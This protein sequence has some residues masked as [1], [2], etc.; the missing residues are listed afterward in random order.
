MPPQFISF[1]KD[2]LWGAATSAFQIEGS[3]LADGAAK[4]NWYNWT[5]TPGKVDR[6]QDAD[7]AC[8]H[9]HRYLEDVALMKEMGLKTYRFSISWP[10]V[11][12]ERGRANEKA[13][14]FYRRLVD[15]VNQA[16][17][18]PNAT[19]FHWE[20]PVWIKG[21]WENPEI[22]PAFREYAEVVF[23]KLGKDVPYWATH[24]EPICVAQLGYLDGPFPPGKH[25]KKAYAKV[26]HHLTLAHH[27]TVKSYRQMNLGG[28]IGWVL[29]LT[30]SKTIHKGPV[31]IKHAK[32]LNDL[33]NGVFLAPSAGRSYPDFLFDYSGESASLYEKELKAVL[34]PLDFLGVNHY[35]PN[36]TQYSPGANI[37][38]N[39]TS[40]PPGI[41]QNDLDWAVEPQSMYDLLTGIWK[42]YG[43][44]KILVTENG[45]PTRDSTRTPQE[46]MEDDVRIHYLGTY[47][48]AVHRAMKEG[49]PVKGY[50]AWSLLDNF[51]WCFGYDPRF[52][53]IHVDFKT[54]K[55][56]FKKSAHWYRKV[57][58]DNG[59]DM[60]LLDKNPSYRR[61]QPSKA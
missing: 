22:V 11:I 30:P 48:E 12:P 55:R 10:R 5:K 42:E 35:F 7:M 61:Y 4:S 37:M 41:F 3:P 54:Q 2:F 8:D 38:D 21:E 13:L 52:G 56:T 17:I 39:E 28:E 46:T 43:F 14:D 26:V 20:V 57:I 36:Y 18:I 16:G 25:D 44:Q 58:A 9:Y 15:A 60:D 1:P 34:Q 49:V 51:E 40:L 6:G 47:I 45:F 53:I 19:L 50:Y 32:N 23:K 31:E 29:S 59:F 33:C 27:L 24:N